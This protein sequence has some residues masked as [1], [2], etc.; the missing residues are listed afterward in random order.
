[1]KL[2]LVL[3]KVLN[4]QVLIEVI[5]HQRILATAIPRGVFN[6]LKSPLLL[7]TILPGPECACYTITTCRPK[8]GETIKRQGT[9]NNTRFLKATAAGHEHSYKEDNSKA[10]PGEN[11]VVSFILSE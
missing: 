1:M 3:F 7:A 5:A 2:Q 4:L 11:A 9:I 6:Q 8:T 10:L